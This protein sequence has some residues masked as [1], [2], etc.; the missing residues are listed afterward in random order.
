VVLQV[1]RWQLCVGMS[2]CSA[3]FGRRSDVAVVPHVVDLLWYS[4]RHRCR[5]SYC[6]GSQTNATGAVCVRRPWS[7][8]PSI[9]RD[10]FDPRH[11]VGGP[12]PVSG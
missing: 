10:L 9:L 4:G 3:A 11:L 5:C 12:L 7:A 8:S 2:C 6:G 1:D